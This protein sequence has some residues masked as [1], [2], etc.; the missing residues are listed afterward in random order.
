MDHQRDAVRSGFWPLYRFH[1][2]LD[3]HEHPFHLDSRKPSLPL[4]DFFAGEARFAMLQRSDPEQAARLQAL[5]QADAD[6]RWR[7]Y[8]QLAGVERTLPQESSEE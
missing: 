5:A 8:A 4:R 7:W 2:G 6:E 3:P 1:P